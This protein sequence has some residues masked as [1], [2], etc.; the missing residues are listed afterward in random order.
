MSIAAAAAA[1]AAAAGGAAASL[2][3]EGIRIRREIG[4]TAVKGRSESG[5]NQL[6]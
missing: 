1:A 2:Y 4:T 6:K 5:R 3:R